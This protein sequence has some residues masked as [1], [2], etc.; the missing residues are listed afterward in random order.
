MHSVPMYRDVP[1][2]MWM[3]TS[4]Q[5][6]FS[7]KL[8]THSKTWRLWDCA[9]TTGRH[10]NKHMHTG[11]L[12]SQMGFEKTLLWGIK[13]LARHWQLTYGVTQRWVCWGTAW[14]VEMNSLIL[15]CTSEENNYTAKELNLSVE[16]SDFTILMGLLLDKTISLE[17]GSFWLCKCSE[18]SQC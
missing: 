6:C 3:S 18:T 14:L 7:L 5:L 16:T 9:I 10:S 8:L 13:H 15:C 1:T 2:Y 17:E 4:G 12:N 11:P